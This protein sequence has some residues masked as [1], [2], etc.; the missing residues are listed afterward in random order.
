VYHSGLL[1]TANYTDSHVGA[2]Q[3]GNQVV[4]RIQ[5]PVIRLANFSIYIFR[6]VVRPEISR[7]IRQLIRITDT[8]GIADVLA[9]VSIIEGSVIS[10]NIWDMQIAYFAFPD[11]P[12]KIPSNIYFHGGLSSSSTLDLLKDIR[13]KT[14]KELK[15]FTVLISDEYGITGRSVQ[16]AAHITVPGIADRGDESLPEGNYSFKTFELRVVPNN[17]N[18]V[19]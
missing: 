7:T 15:V 1:Q 6:N 14:L 5:A 8:H 4:Y 17:Y 18:I 9:A 11:F 3:A 2:D 16:A 19:I 13:N 12:Q 10:E